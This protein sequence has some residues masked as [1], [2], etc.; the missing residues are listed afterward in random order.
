MTNS[1]LRFLA[2]TAGALC[3]L[4]L[5]AQADDASADAPD[6]PTLYINAQ[7]TAN[8]TPVTTYES[9]VSNLEFNPRVDLQVRNMAEAQGDVTIRGGI[10]ENTGFRVGS[11]TII[12]P[13]TGHYFAELP[14]AP[15]ML[16]T[17]DV[18]TGADNA[19][20]GFNST[21][22]TISY[23]W[24]RINDGGS[25]TAGGGDHDLNFQRI[26][27]GLTGKLSDN[28]DWT[29]GAEAEFSRSESDG[30]IS[31]G[32]HDFNRTTGRFQI[33]SPNSQTDFFAGY[34][35]KDF[36]WPGMYTANPERLEE[37]YLKTRLFM[38]NHLHNYGDENTFELTG[39]Y[40]RH[41]DHYVLTSDNPSLYEAFHETEVG[42]LG[43][44][45][46]HI[47]SEALAVN[48]SAQVTADNID[49]KDFFNGSA[50]GGLERGEF[51]S[52]TYHK[53]AILPEYTIQV[54][55]QRSL[56][57]RVGLAYDDTNRDDSEFSSI[58]DLTLK[59]SHADGEYD[60]VYLSHAKASQVAGYTAIGGG[61]SGGLF[62]SNYDLDRETSQ[63]LELGAVISRSDW[64]LEAAIFHRW[65]DDLVDWTYSAGSPFARSAEGV[66]IET[67]GIE[68][69]GTKRW[70]AIEAIASYTYLDKD[71][72]YGD[73]A[74]DASFY[75]LNYANHRATLGAIWRPIDI[76]EVRIDN[77]WR[78]NEDNAL[79]NSDDEAFFTHFG[80]SF[81]PE[82]V[83]GL[84]I[85][86]AIDNA[87]DDD[88]QDVPGTPG[89]GD[90]YSAG[91]TYR[92]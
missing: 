35:E 29:W 11:A 69:I 51:Q 81:Y 21:V 14:I 40:R 63:N 52:R 85:F 7:Q 75:A 82:Q 3:L 19:L 70:G 31:G 90:Q 20:F 15:E 44:S 42:S 50:L 59:N 30:T 91:A 34:Q 2:N 92:W 74:V 5:A 33:V 53:A 16:T 47:I 27:Q 55:E 8:T 45:G 73:A 4:T 62:R 49:S 10:F 39:Y 48:Y 32:D 12:D 41:N 61:T 1:K 13:Q 38:I 6:L 76:I 71:E 28:G 54:K 17:P 58:F 57:A 18:L 80:L 88:F 36:G 56:T 72:D 37:E 65:D 60:S 23:G 67:L 87:W 78:K 46:R 9:P 79:R 68:L 86:F 77:E 24:T 25:L 26:H 22:G 83:A 43:L 89:R 64:S 84:E 66:D